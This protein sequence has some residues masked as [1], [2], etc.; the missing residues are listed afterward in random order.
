MTSIIQQAIDEAY[1]GSLGPGS[2]P[3]LS[4]QYTRQNTSYSGCDI[5]AIVNVPGGEPKIIANI[6]TLSYS[7][8][9]EKYAV[10]PHGYTYPKGFV[11][12]RRSLAGTM[13][14]SVFDRHALW[15]ISKQKAKIDR[16]S[17]ERAFS[18]LGDQMIP[19]DIA[20]IFINEQGR[21][22]KLNLYG[23]ELVDEGMVMSVNDIYTESTHVFRARD[24]DIL[25]PGDNPL[26]ES[27]PW[28]PG[29]TY[30]FDSQ[31]NSVIVT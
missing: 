29:M 21:Q 24:I 3:T 11:R 10:T 5:R 30:T 15:D 27:T 14:F 16:S 22:S 31:T 17:G 19:F 28:V 23:I 26:M 25:M 9:R 6:H 2:S 13:V 18:L 20:C 12:G 1:L 7:I 4:S 8:H